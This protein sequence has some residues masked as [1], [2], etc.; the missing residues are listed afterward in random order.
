MRWDDLFGDLERE[1]EAAAAAEQQAETAELTRAEL[2][3][4]A[5]VDRL[6]GSVGCALRIHTVGGHAAGELARVAGDCVLLQQATTELLVPL[7]AVTAVEGLADA[8]VPPGLV[9]AVESR[10]GF[11]SL[12]RAVARDRSEVTVQRTSGHAVHG[13]PTRVGSDF[14]ELALHE[15]GEV[16]RPGAVTG[17]LA[18]PFAA[19][20]VV[21]RHR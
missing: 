4:V 15:P 5:L 7:A 21:R 9:G 10:L 13:T 20:S 3:Q 18:V 12:L 8:T 1:W 16:P 14:V 6:R 11:A 19:V 2:A 17:V